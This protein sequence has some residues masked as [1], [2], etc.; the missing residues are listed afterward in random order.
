MKKNI[1]SIG[2]KRKKQYQGIDLFH[3]LIIERT[4]RMKSVNKAQNVEPPIHYVVE[5]KVAI[6]G[7]RMLRGML[8]QYLL[9]RQEIIVLLKVEPTLVKGVPTAIKVR[10]NE[11]KHNH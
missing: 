5:Q 1:N 4:M 3:L 10:Y 9:I 7:I 6:Q 8:S 2:R 11:P